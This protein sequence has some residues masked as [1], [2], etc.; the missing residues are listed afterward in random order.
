M[1]RVDVVASLECSDREVIHRV[2]EHEIHLPLRTS[3]DAANGNTDPL[4]L[5]IAPQHTKG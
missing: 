4:V 2:V 3:H 5:S 1:N